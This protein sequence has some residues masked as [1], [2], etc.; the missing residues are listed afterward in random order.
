MHF[1]VLARAAL[2][3]YVLIAG[4]NVFCCLKDADSAEQ[5]AS[6]NPLR[7]NTVWLNFLQFCVWSFVWI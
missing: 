5:T 7:P 4:Y 3:I 6:L 2:D 1:P